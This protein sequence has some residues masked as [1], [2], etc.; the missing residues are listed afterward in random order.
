M[1]AARITARLVCAFGLAATATATAA[2]AGVPQVIVP[3]FGDQFYW[4][5]RVRAL[6]IGSSV[7]GPLTTDTLS[8]ALR[9]AL[10]PGVAPRSRSLAEQLGSDGAM[11]AARRLAAA[12]RR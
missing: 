4:D 9:E 11:V 6:R 1:G 5:S 8:T 12:N 10:E 3:M 2:R 7:V